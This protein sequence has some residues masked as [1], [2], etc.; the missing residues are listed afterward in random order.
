[1]LKNELWQSRRDGSALME[2]HG[3][4]GVFSDA[5]VDAAR[6]FN[7]TYRVSK[8]GAGAVQLGLGALGFAGTITTA[9]LACATVVGYYANG[10]L[11]VLSADQVLAGAK[12][13]VYGRPAETYLSHSLQTLGMSPEAAGWMEAALG[14]GSA[15]KAALVA[16]KAIG[17]NGIEKAVGA[18]TSTISSKP[19][20]YSVAFETKL[21]AADFGRSRDVHFNRSNAA[22]DNALKVDAD[23]AK[24]M[25]DLIP[26]VQSSVSSVGGRATPTGWTW[27]H[28]SRTAASGQQSHAPRSD[29]SIHSG[30]PILARP[31]P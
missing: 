11:A 10:T 29:K 19:S 9:P 24:M 5:N 25:D 13:L 26:N 1:M 8:R 22:L 23:F 14:L 30:F 3:T 20:A 7:D 15:A 18:N 21:N 28:A 17:Q 12:Q 16:N 6:K 4:S 27:E 2:V 31:S